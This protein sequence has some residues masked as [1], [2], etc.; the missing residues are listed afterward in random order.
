MA[1]PITADLRRESIDLLGVGGSFTEKLSTSNSCDGET[2]PLRRV[3]L[4]PDQDS[5]KSEE[6]T[7]QN[8]HKTK[9]DKRGEY[10]LGKT[11]GLRSDEYRKI[12]NYCFRFLEMPRGFFETVYHAL[13]FFLVIASLVLTV[14]STVHTEDRNYEEILQTPILAVEIILIVI[15][16]IEY[17]VRLWSAGCRSAYVGIKGRL[18]FAVQL[19]SI[20]DM[21]VIVSSIVAVSL[22]SNVSTSPIR[23]L[24]FLP[25]LRV[26]RFDRQ[27]ETWRLLGSVIYVHR[28]ELLTT[29]YL[30]FISLIFASFVLYMVEKD[31]NADLESWPSSFWWGIVTLTTVGYGDTV[32]VTWYGKCC[33][34][35]FALCGISFF[36]LPAGILGSGF[37][38][39]VTQQQRQKH[40]HRRRR[41]AAV[42]LQSYWRLFCADL[43]S[44]SVATWLPSI[45]YNRQQHLLKAVMEKTGTTGTTQD[46]DGLSDSQR[47]RKRSIWS[48]QKGVRRGSYDVVQ[49]SRSDSL[50]TGIIDRKRA[51]STCTLDHEFFDENALLALQ[52]DGERPC[53]ALTNAQKLAIRLI[54]ILK[55][56]VAIRKFKEA[57]RPYDVKDVIEQYSTGHV[58]ML[59]RV[60]NLQAKMDKVF[61]NMVEGGDDENAGKQGLTKRLT[62]VEHQVTIIDSKLELVL[63]MLQNIQNTR[64]SPSGGSHPYDL[65]FR[66]NGDGVSSRRSSV[67]RAHS[68]PLDMRTQTSSEPHRIST[69]VMRSPDIPC[70]TL[71]DPESF[72]SSGS[73]PTSLSSVHSQ[74]LHG[75][76]SG[77]DQH[78]NMDHLDGVYLSETGALN[79]PL[80]SRNLVTDKRQLSDVT[81][82]SL[83]DSKENVGGLTPPGPISQQNSTTS[84]TEPGPG[85]ADSSANE[86]KVDEPV[87]EK[88]ETGSSES[89]RRKRSLLNLGETE[90]K[91][92]DDKEASDANIPSDTG[93]EKEA[94][95]WNIA[96]RYTGT[97]ERRDSISG[98]RSSL[99]RGAHG[100]SDDEPSSH[101]VQEGHFDSSVRSAPTRMS[102]K[103]RPLVKSNPV[104]V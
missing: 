36:A 65:H 51:A 39:K 8:G 72:Q 79:A 90:T 7:I 93:E 44:K 94:D 81:E 26:L 80:M 25:L 43:D 49:S 102:A 57:R 68:D 98:E 24:R 23:L 84:D 14:L 35:L 62:R 74:S 89:R 21:I 27:G 48:K 56:R 77:G 13:L 1:R 63:Q 2:V 42:L 67:S 95:E 17:I 85:G 53:I 104:E 71:S 75:S 54:R 59:A 11:W 76:V 19:Y 18:R 58:E 55:L 16:V 64:G 38:L 29:F 20:I 22:A 83:G 50:L 78:Q 4:Q 46:D 15:F 12:Q 10:R 41:P 66:S 33:A 40:F 31:S 99:P 87:W 37:A 61:N 100:Q 3:G 96:E 5:K 52:Q 86:Q 101:A 73:R 6:F 60:K 47:K 28:Q 69:H 9:D 92:P 88:R 30:G 32:P 97:P 82:E 34:A 70:V 45:Y 103:R 91:S